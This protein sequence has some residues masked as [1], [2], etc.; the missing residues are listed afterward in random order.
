MESHCILSVIVPVA[1]DET[2]W[3]A[4]LD[5]LAALPAPSEVI[6]VRAAHDELAIPSSWLQDLHIRQIQSFPG[7]ARQM[8]LGARL[9]G[10]RWLW[11]LHA[12]TRLGA[13][14]L[15]ALNQFLASEREALGWFDLKF[16]DDGPAL[17]RLNARGARWRS[18]W[19]GLPFGDQ[20]FVIPAAAFAQLGG[21]DETVRYG[22]DHLL[23]WAAHA[24]GLPLHPIGATLFTSARKYA[25]H[26]W[27]R[28]TLRHWLLTL[29]QALPAWWR[30]RRRLRR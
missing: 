16:R 26:G 9:A 1:P 7:R 13:T 8:N 19:L 29:R 21:Y 22:E 10:G 6:L 5:D 30:S 4:L 17:T 27:L 3:C 25:A 18:R 2:Q 15:T 28:T 11:F 20:G 12:D 14:V 23:V 24:H